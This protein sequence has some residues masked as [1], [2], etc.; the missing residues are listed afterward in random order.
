MIMLR[1]LATILLIL[2]PFQLSHSQTPGDGKASSGVKTLQD[3]SSAYKSLDGISGYR[4]SCEGGFASEF[5]CREVDLLSFMTLE[6]LGDSDS[7]GLRASDVWGWE[8]PATGREYALVGRSVGTAF[9][10]VTDPVNPFLVGNLPRT[11]GSR[12]SIWRDI[13]VYR[14]VAYVVADGAGNHGLQIFD[15][16]ALRSVSNPPALFSADLTYL[17]FGSAHNVAINEE[18]GYAYVVGASDIGF[19]GEQIDNVKSTGSKSCG[20]GLHMVDIRDPLN[21]EFAGCFADPSTGF[22]GTGYTHDAQCVTYDGPDVRYRGREIC[23]GLNE[24]GIS[25]AD[26]TDKSNPVAISVGR[27]PD[28]GYIH[29][30]WLTEDHRFLVVD[31]EGDERAFARSTHTKIFDLTD[32]EVPILA[33]SFENT[34][35]SIDHNLYIKGLL[36]FQANYTS[37]LRILDVR[38]PLHVE[39]IG[40]FDTTPADSSVSFG[41]TWS[42]YPFFDSGTILLS[43]IHEG[44]F[45]LEAPAIQIEIPDENAV[46]EV[47]PNPFNASTNLSIALLEPEEVSIVIYDAI[48]REVTVLHSGVLGGRR[49][50]RFSWTPDSEASGSY[51]IRIV[52]PSFEESRTITL[53]K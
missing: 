33:T 14:D 31:D 39:E 22:R 41:G 12:A 29:Q 17:N 52:G 8:D 36:G 35:S 3:Q 37:G 24:N 6:Q 40:F 43:S 38:D 28:Y 48:G 46:S 30:G 10:D 34:T 15:L 32:L 2:L 20:G 44:L 1:P 53:L 13:K 51:V 9:V 50:H 7:G 23:F 27:Y 4:A 11:T 21:P 19:R 49:V 47:W 16:R 18:T 45:V 5:P 26:V 25:I 42:V